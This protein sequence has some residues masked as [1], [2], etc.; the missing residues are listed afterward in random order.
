MLSFSYAPLPIMRRQSAPPRPART[1]VQG[2]PGMSLLTH[3]VEQT[4][5]P[6]DRHAAARSSAR[7]AMIKRVCSRALAVL[8]MG[9]MLAGLIAVKTVLFIPSFKY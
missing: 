7:W 6:S 9:G 5:H 2:I 8:L 4:F 3:R 1:R